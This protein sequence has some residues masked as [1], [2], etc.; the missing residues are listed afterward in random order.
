MALII[1]G[2]L[3]IALALWTVIAPRQQWRVLNAW[4]YRD[5]GANEPSDLS[6]NLGRAAGAVTIMLVIVLG[7]V[8]I[9]AESSP[10]ADARDARKARDQ[11]FGTSSVEMA[12]QPPAVGTG[13]AVP[14]WRFVP[15]DQDNADRLDLDPPAGTDL[16]VAVDGV[17]RVNGLTVR[18]QG[19]TVTVTVTGTCT[20]GEMLCAP[21]RTAPFPPVHLYPVDLK[22][23]VGT[24]ELIDQNAER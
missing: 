3:L 24:R 7:A 15:L 13:D 11:R 16:V 20:Q 21:G 23:P 2:V 19:Q 18:E 8:L 10:E 14:V 5:P 1:G 4:R 22:S 9:R 6:Y 12:T 17:Y